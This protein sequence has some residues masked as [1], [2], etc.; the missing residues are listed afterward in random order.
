MAESPENVGKFLDQLATKLR[1]LLEQEYEILLNYKKEE[2]FGKDL[3]FTEYLV[4]G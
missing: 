3:Q 2:V 1:I 4:F